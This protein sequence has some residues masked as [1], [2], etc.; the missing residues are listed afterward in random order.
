[1]TGAPQRRI[2]WLVVI[3]GLATSAA[4]SAAGDSGLPDCA[5]AAYDKFTDRTAV[6]IK[7]QYAYKD[8]GFMAATFGA[9]ISA[10]FQCPGANLQRPDSMTLEVVHGA[11]VLKH[12]GKEDEVQWT[13]AQEGE[14]ILNVILDSRRIRLGAMHY[15]RGDEAVS[16]LEAENLQKPYSGALMLTRPELLTITMPTDSLLALFEAA[17]TEGRVGAFQFYL[18]NTRGHAAD[19]YRDFAKFVRALPRD[20][21]RTSP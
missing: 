19:H 8:A 13:F 1:M 4:W 9:Q 17:S 18:Q 14:H 5:R 3:L 7:N 10:Y 20:S 15:L 12:Y 2:S 16:F 11:P 21:A 6:Q